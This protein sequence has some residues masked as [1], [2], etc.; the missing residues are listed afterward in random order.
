MP[1]P[2]EPGHQHFV[3]ILSHVQG[4]DEWDHDLHI[5]QSHLSSGNLHGLATCRHDATPDSGTV[6]IRAD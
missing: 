5:L 6:G 1:Q 2:R 3:D 4:A